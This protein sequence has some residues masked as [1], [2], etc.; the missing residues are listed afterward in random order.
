MFSKNLGDEDRFTE[1]HNAGSREAFSSSEHLEGT[2]LGGKKM[3]IYV[4][5]LREK[6]VSNRSPKQ[7]PAWLIN[8]MT[9]SWQKQWR[10]KGKKDHFH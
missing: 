4:Y 3:K 1:M 2:E 10:R 6:R 5:E 9:N 8:A 7:L